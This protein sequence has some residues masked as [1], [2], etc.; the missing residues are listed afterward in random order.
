M[1]IKKVCEICGADY[2]VPHWRAGTAKYCSVQCQRK[3][4]ICGPNATC[5]VC[6]KP[7]YIKP[8]RLKRLKHPPCCSLKCSSLYRK[9]WFRGK[10][11]HQDGL[12]GNKN[13]TFSGDVIFQKNNKLT[14]ARK[15]APYRVDANKAGRVLEH[16]LLVEENWKLFDERAFDIINGQHVLK[17]GYVVH[18]IDGYHSNNDIRNLIPLTKSEH[19]RL[20]IKLREVVRDKETG[21]IITTYKKSN[22]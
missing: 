10:G 2:F 14:E 18:H 22:T 13:S 7:F 16:R 17:K 5:V 6:G 15:Y 4:L 19:N 12:K 9:V 8:N 11:N 1:L 20:H 3:S 21:R